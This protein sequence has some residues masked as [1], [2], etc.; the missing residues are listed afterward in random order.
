MKRSSSPA[1]DKREIF[2][3]ASCRRGGIGLLGVLLTTFVVA[4]VG[5]GVDLTRM[6]LVKS[7]L[8]TS[9]DAAAL[10]A[11]R[12]MNLPVNVAETDAKAL[13]WSNFGRTGASTDPNNKGYKGYLGAVAGDPTFTRP[14]GD[15]NT[16]TINAT[17]TVEMTLMAIVGAKTTTV[18][19]QASAKRAVLGMELALVL[20][21]T[22]SMGPNVDR[23]NGPTN[24]GSNIA[25]QRAAATNLMNILFGSNDTQP[26]LFVSVVQFVAS[27]NMGTQN[28][29]W[30][31]ELP[32]SR[33]YG[34]A[35][36]AG[37]VEARSGGE[38]QTDTPPI[39]DARFTPFLWQSTM[40]KYTYKSGTSIS[41]RTRS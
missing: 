24:T 41:R 12:E 31:K 40:D 4:A 17:A 38:D 30:L 20:D 28:T 32:D 39:G 22:G 34:N 36:W 1:R 6:M 19:A 35:G 2:S 5:L 25:A 8:Q 29:Q 15:V 3:L 27:V 21:V 10:V 11:G 7:R 14:S 23:D 26:N 16:V 9:V 37:C 18:P 13:F 33:K